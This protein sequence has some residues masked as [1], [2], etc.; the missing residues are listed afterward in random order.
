MPGWI[1]SFSY[2]NQCGKWPSVYRVPLILALLLALIVTWGCATDEPTAAA[3]P[4]STLRP[5]LAVGRPEPSATAQP[6]LTSLDSTMPMTLTIWLPP[7][8]AVSALSSGLTFEMINQSFRAANPGVFLEVV[9]KAAYGTGGLANALLATRPVVPSRLPDIIAIDTALVSELARQDI[10]VPLDDAIPETIWASLYPA[11]L[12]NTSLEG[13]RYA[14]PFQVDISFL[15]YNAGDV[16]IAPRT[17][18]EL[19]GSGGKYVFPAAQ[20]DGS[21]ADAFLLQYLA[22]GGAILNEGGQPYLDSS[23]MASVLAT[24]RQAVDAGVVPISVRNLQTLDDCWRAYMQ[25][26]ATMTNVGSSQYQREKGSLRKTRYASIPTTSGVSATL[27][28]SWSWAIVT[29]DPF[30]QEIASRYLLSALNPKALSSWCV[31]SHHLPAHQE[32]LV[33]AVE[34]EPYRVFLDEQLRHA[35]PYPDLAYY[36]RLQTIVTRAIEDVLD[37][38]STPERA[39][40]TAAATVARLR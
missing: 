12:D 33:L 4:A 22:E 30:R 26:K 27:A 18:T 15:A 8:M 28:R 21:A 25:D 3:A 31:E 24:Y 38:V 14:I 35:Y 5:T 34:D 2:Q 20:G 32:A 11:V 16:Q 19:E 9:P 7:E 23:I 36:T 17:W 40:V 10:L 29:R 39:A 6:T 37:G 1:G 13:R